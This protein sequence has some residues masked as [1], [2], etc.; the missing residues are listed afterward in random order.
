MI[1][2]NTRC[3]VDKAPFT[4]RSCDRETT[5]VEQC[6]AFIYSSFFLKATSPNYTGTTQTRGPAP[7]DPSHV[8]VTQT[9][10]N[11]TTTKLGT[12]FDVS[13]S[14]VRCHG[15]INQ[16]CLFYFQYDHAGPATVLFPVDYYKTS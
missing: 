11:R 7:Q 15:F 5:P 12:I 16:S 3:C 13:L 6:E 10:P 9:R 8:S 14:F 2:V 4:R 1:T